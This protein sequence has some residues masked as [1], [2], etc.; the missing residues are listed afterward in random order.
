MLATNVPWPRPSPGAFGVSF[1]SVS[2]AITRLPKSGRDES[3]PE[4]TTAIVGDCAA[5]VDSS[6]HRPSTRAAYGQ[7]CWLES[8]GGAGGTEAAATTALASE[9]ALA[10]PTEFDAVTERRSVDPTCA[11]VGVNCDPVAPAMSVQPPPA[12]SQ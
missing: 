10:E 4:S 8:F 2:C 5:S 11:D 7:S 9:F 6:C 3:M 1:V 12:V